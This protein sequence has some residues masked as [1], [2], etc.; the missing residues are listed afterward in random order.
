M[1]VVQQVWQNNSKSSI[2]EDKNESFKNCQQKIVSHFCLSI[3]IKFIFSYLTRRS[4]V[5]CI[6]L[7]IVYYNHNLFSH[8]FNTHHLTFVYFF[9]L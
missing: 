7:P 2:T 8:D 9:Y 3:T 5:Y 4:G 6:Q 1:T